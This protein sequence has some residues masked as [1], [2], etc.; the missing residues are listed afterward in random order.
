MYPDFPDPLLVRRALGSGKL[1][2]EF[3]E[4][5]EDGDLVFALDELYHVCVH[6]SLS[7]TW[8]RHFA[9]LVVQGVERLS[10]LDT[11]NPQLLRKRVVGDAAR[12]SHTLWFLYTFDEAL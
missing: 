8:R 5:T 2:N 12:Q 1:D 7:S 4:A 6:S 3:I 10:N 9:I 11:L